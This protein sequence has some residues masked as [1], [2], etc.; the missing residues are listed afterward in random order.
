[1]EVF[2]IPEQKDACPADY[3]CTYWGNPNFGLNNWDNIF[4]AALMTL[5]IIA[6][7]GW[8]DNMYQVRRFTHNNYFD[9]Y[10]LLTVIFGAFFVMNLLIAV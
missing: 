7:E 10:F 8:A 1:L 4:F 5:E 2:C 3:T 6:L 9:V